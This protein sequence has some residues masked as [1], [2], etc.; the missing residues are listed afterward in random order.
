M[1]RAIR[2]YPLTVL[3]PLDSSAHEVGGKPTHAAEMRRILRVLTGERW[4]ENEGFSTVRNQIAQAVYFQS[5]ASITPRTQVYRRTL[6][7]PNR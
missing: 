2:T 1:P 4:G 5:H 7:P 3:F 6:R